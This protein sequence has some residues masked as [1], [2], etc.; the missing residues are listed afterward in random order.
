MRSVWPEMRAINTILAIEAIMTKT[1]KL[2]TPIKAIFCFLG[3]LRVVTTGITIMMSQVLV[4]VWS[5]V[6]A[7][8]KGVGFGKQNVSPPPKNDCIVTGLH[9]NRSPTS[10][11][12][13]KMTT[14]M[15]VPYC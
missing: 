2:R 10:M 3:I 5:T 1:P 11:G 6:G 12:M 13:V 4:V 9:S 15:I 8:R 7:M 14:K